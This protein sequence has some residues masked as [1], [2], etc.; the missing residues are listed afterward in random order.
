MAQAPRDP[1]P[2]PRWRPA[3]MLVVV[4]IIAATARVWM[5]GSMPLIITNDSTGYLEWGRE[6]ASGKATTIPPIRTPGYPLFLAAVYDTFG[7]NAVGV[8]IAQH[9]LGVLSALI[10][11]AAVAR[12]T[13]G[14]PLSR[15]CAI[16]AGVLSS[17]DP[18]QLAFE[19]YA[20]TETLSCF[21]MVLAVAL[22]LLRPQRAGTGL[23]IGL[24]LGALLGFACLVRPSFQSVI[25][26]L[27]L[28]WLLHSWR[29]WRWAAV[30]T[31]ALAIGLGATIAPW[32]AHN[33]RRNVPGLATGT[34]VLMWTGLCRTSLLSDTFEL[35]PEV[36]TAYATLKADPKHEG[37]V[38]EFL[39]AIN[40]W[41]DPTRRQLLVDWTRASIRENP[42]R[43]ASVLFEAGLWQLNRF[44]KN[45]IFTYSETAGFTGR[46]GLDGTKYGFAAPNFQFNAVAPGM[47][48]FAMPGGVGPPARA[49]RW[50]E[51]HHIEGLPQIP[52]L[53]GAVLCGVAGLRR[54]ATWGVSLVIAGT[55]AYYFAHA[56]MLLPFSRYSMP[57]WA[58]WYIPLGMLIPLSAGLFRR[59]SPARMTEEAYKSGSPAPNEARPATPVPAPVPT[60]EPVS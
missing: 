48:T 12:A 42:G 35:P 56:A 37:K 54:R 43:Y 59:G 3:R 1:L 58:A 25:P 57:A 36:A 19:S 6:F 39:N 55:G 22:A 33:H 18:W 27:A 10:V 45:S 38:H 40:G 4:F 51:L 28:G 9:A 2:P 53:L 60:Q 32:L 49:A 17:L 13:R 7:V 44:P 41:Y 14:L 29:S 21:C 16:A 11:A 30:Y 52:L 26:F 46:L 24:L 23:V 5:L 8:L 20:L 31:A 47:A 34:E 15:G 50:L